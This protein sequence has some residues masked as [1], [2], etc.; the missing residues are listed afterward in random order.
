LFANGDFR[1]RSISTQI[2]QAG[3]PK[4]IAHAGIVRLY[5]GDLW[6]AATSRP[7]FRRD[8]YFQNS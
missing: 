4:D 8:D 2:K 6:I 1:T 7:A 5:Q 3:L